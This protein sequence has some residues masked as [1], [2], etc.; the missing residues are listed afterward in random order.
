[1]FELI[2]RDQRNSFCGVDRSHDGRIRPHQNRGGLEADQFRQKRSKSLRIAVRK[3]VFDL[4]VLALRVAQIAQAIP[5]RCKIA[6]RG[7]YRKRRHDANQRHSRLLRAHSERPR[8]C[9]AAQSTD[10]FPPCDFDR[11]RT[12]QRGSRAPN[13]HK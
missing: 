11:H 8:E 6:R 3:P 9:C 1:V 2:K 7:G 10:E 12:L 13:C 5:Q 4:E